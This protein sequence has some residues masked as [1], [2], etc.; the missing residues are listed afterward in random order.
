MQ[1]LKPKSTFLWAAACEG[2]FLEPNLIKFNEWWHQSWNKNE[3]GP[4]RKSEEACRPE[5]SMEKKHLKSLELPLEIRDVSF[6]LNWPA[7]N[8]S[9]MFSKCR[10]KVTFFVLSIKCLRLKNINIC[11]FS[12]NE[13]T[14]D[15]WRMLRTLCA[16]SI[17]CTRVAP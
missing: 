2:F 9:L 15:N 5:A 11:D 8:S 4:W 6:W 10:S 17:Y 1:I 14:K 16:L 13:F 12:W 7:E 3:N